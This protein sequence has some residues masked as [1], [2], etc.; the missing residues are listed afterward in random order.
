VGLILVFDVFGL[1]EVCRRLLFGFV[2]LV[3]GRRAL[4]ALLRGLFLDLDCFGRGGLLRALL[5]RLL[6]H[7][8]SSLRDNDTSRPRIR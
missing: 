3:V 7:G 4:F 8:G 5:L 6:G 1:G 2:Q